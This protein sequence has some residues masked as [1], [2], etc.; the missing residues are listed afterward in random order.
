MQGS[1]IINLQRAGKDPEPILLS[2][3]PALDLIRKMF[4]DVN[5]KK[6]FVLEPQVGPRIPMPV[7]RGTKV[8]SESALLNLHFAAERGK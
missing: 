2:Y 4:A 5:N 1:K 3:V 7:M 6:G 8:G